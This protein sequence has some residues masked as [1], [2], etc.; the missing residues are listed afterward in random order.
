MS[1]FKNEEP[2]DIEGRIKNYSLLKDYERALAKNALEGYF[3]GLKDQVQP[4]DKKELKNFMIGYMF[5]FLKATYNR[6]GLT[7]FERGVISGTFRIYE[8]KRE[9]ESYSTFLSKLE[10]IIKRMEELDFGKA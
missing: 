10:T 4:I 6:E 3:E 1:L 9:L 8:G 5:A 2:L 7:L